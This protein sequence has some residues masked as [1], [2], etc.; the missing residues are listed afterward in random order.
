MAA[1][2]PATSTAATRACSTAAAR[3]SSGVD[4]GAAGKAESGTTSIILDP[5]PDAATPIRGSGSPR[6]HRRLRHDVGRVRRS[7]FPRP[8]APE[9]L[10]GRGG[11]GGRNLPDG[12]RPG[13]DDAA[14]AVRLPHRRRRADH[15][16]DQPS[17]ARRRPPPS[18]HPSGGRQLPGAPG[19]RI[20]AASRA[21]GAGDSGLSGLLWVN[22]LH[23]AGDAMIAVSLAGTLFFAAA[24]DAQRWNVTLCLLITMAPCAVLAPVIGPAL[25]RLQRGR[26]WALA[27]SLLGRAV[28]AIVLA[29]HH[30]DLALYPAA[31]GVL[32]L[33]KA[34]NVLRAAVV[35]RVL[36]PAL[37]LTSANARLSVFGLAASG[38]CGALAAGI[39][40]LSGFGW[41]LGVTTAVFCA[42]AVPAVRLLRHV[43]VPAGEEP[44]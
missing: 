32:V 34:F 14:P 21:D 36:P 15:A 22:A 29:A 41:E 27:G 35:P 5:P 43:D 40:A 25:D 30:D 17:S 38:A 16:P 3:T 2:P 28:L 37:S 33:S 23:M 20:R 11:A 31:L 42:A 13:A 9:A 18:A 12:D 24:A 8:P 10:V 1:A 6:A 19:R 44:A 4:P 7:P 39:A 26:R